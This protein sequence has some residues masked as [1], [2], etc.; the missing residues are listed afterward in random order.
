[1]KENSKVLHR[2]GCY[3]PRRRGIYW[4]FAQKNFSEL[5]C[6]NASTL[7]KG[8][9][10]LKVIIPP[11]GTSFPPSAGKH[12]VSVFKDTLQ[13]LLPFLFQT[14]VFSTSHTCSVFIRVFSMFGSYLLLSHMITGVFSSSCLA[15]T[16][17]RSTSVLFLRPHLLVTGWMGKW[18]SIKADGLLIFTAI[19][20]EETFHSK[21]PPKKLLDCSL[22]ANLYASLTHQIFNSA[23]LS[24]DQ[25]TP[26]WGYSMWCPSAVKT[27]DNLDYFIPFGY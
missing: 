2:I 12:I 16:L 8:S 1:M 5:V 21:K 15:L 14:F 26:R 13:T 11:C 27:N 17:L 24:F 25:T 6:R 10:R 4:H 3:I 23:T 19:H 20:A 18:F 22:C 9:A 7:S